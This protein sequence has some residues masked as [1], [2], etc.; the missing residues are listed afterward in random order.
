MVC[1]V[2]FAHT[3]FCIPVCSSTLLY[4]KKTTTNMEIRNAPFVESVQIGPMA[5]NVFHICFDLDIVPKKCF[6]LRA[7]QI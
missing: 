1:M 4:P 6:S 3:K 5:I 2:T 7:T